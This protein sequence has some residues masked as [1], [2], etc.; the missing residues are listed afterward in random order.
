MIFWIIVA[1]VIHVVVI[2]ALSLGYIRDKWI[3]LTGAEVRKKEAEAQK[4][5]EKQKVE[6]G[7]PTKSQEQIPATQ[8]VASASSVQT[9]VPAPVQPKAVSP[10]KGGDADQKLLEERKNTPMGKRL[11]SVASSNEVARPPT[12]IGISLDDTNPR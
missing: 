5:L 2:G 3:D 4:Q 7:R 6:G 9:A 11:T 1:F 12:D 8:T 10:A